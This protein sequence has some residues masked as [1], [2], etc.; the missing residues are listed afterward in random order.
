M[1]LLPLTF[2]RLT[3][4]ESHKTTSNG[5]VMS[6]SLYLAKTQTSFYFK[7]HSE[8]K[9]KSQWIG[10]WKQLKFSVQSFYDM[11]VLL[12]SVVLLKKMRQKKP[13]ERV[14]GYIHPALNT[15]RRKPLLS[16]P[17][18]N[19]QWRQRFG[20]PCIFF[21]NASS[22]NWSSASEY[23]MYGNVNGNIANIT[24]IVRLSCNGFF[25]EW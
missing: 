15:S 18:F 11:L 23:V 3:K 24:V 19:V 7:W 25:L 8:K 13:S 4:L 21:L 20:D 16:T 2:Q 1:G 17:S 14:L 9:Q 22:Q 10:F 6:K 12:K 5:A